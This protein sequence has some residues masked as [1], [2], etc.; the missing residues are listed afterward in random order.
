MGKQCILGIDVGT[1]AVKVL[2]AEISADGSIEI[3][4]S[5]IVPAVG[6]SKGNI[7]EAPIL[8]SAI[9]Q[10]IECALMAADDAS[11]TQA[12]IGLGG[13]ALRSYN[14]IG[15]IA[16]VSPTFIEKGDVDR[17]C[18][19][20][21][22]ATVPEDYT[23]LDLVPTAFWVDGN[24]AQS[25]P[26]GMNGSRLEVE[27]H[28]TALH[29]VIYNDLKSLLAETG[30]EVTGI[31]SNAI[32]GSI[33][34][35]EQ[36]KQSCLY[37][38]IGAG[39]TDIALYHNRQIRLSASLPLG[40][41]YITNDIMH[42]LNIGRLHAEEVKRYYGKLEKQSLQGKDIILDCNDYGTTDKKVSFD[43]LRDIVESRIQEII[44]LTHHYLSP[45]VTA[46]NPQ[47]IFLTGGCSQMPNIVDAYQKAFNLPVTILSP[48][49]GREYAHPTNTACFGLLQTA[50]SKPVAKPLS[51]SSRAG[52]FDKL[53]NLFK[54]GNRG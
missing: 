4:G 29:Q 51:E 54:T 3:R 45:A 36:H 31:S 53:K 46:Y 10:S 35:P 37:I 49:A 39:L 24:K 22:L 40:G 26:V 19:A 14:S 44:S 43:F 27:V 48:E 17:A 6:F 30:I 18:R 5:G 28:I 11:S 9:S 8:V 32:A 47:M 21:A 1:S 34:I 41:D 7:V 25:D 42:G 50:I 13:N 15:S 23:T 20:A 52:I 2:A 33:S 12:I 16:P 38:D